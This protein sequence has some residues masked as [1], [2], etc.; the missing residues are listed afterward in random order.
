MGRPLT[1]GTKEVGFARES[2]MFADDPD[3][4]YLYGGKLA[5]DGMAIAGVMIGIPSSSLGWLVVH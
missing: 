3:S 2:A 1:Y 5:L 4:V